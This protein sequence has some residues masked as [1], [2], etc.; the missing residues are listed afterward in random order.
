MSGRRIVRFIWFG[1]S[2]VAGLVLGLLAGWSKSAGPSQT[3]FSSL[4]QDYRIDIVLMVAEAYHE[5]QDMNAA[6]D[7]LSYLNADDT[8]QFV[9]QAALD[10]KELGYAKVDLK[11]MAALAQDLDAEINSGSG[12]SP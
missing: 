8:L 5:D 7:R 3:N 9:Q 1:I 10:A 4:R 12:V 2:I 6:K 11:L